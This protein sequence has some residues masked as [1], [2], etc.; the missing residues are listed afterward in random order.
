MRRASY[1]E[2]A[3]LADY[4]DGMRTSAT[5]APGAQRASDGSHLETERYLLRVVDH[6]G[7]GPV[8]LRLRGLYPAVRSCV[9]G[10]HRGLLLDD[11]SRAARWKRQQPEACQEDRLRVTGNAGC[12]GRRPFE[13]KSEGALLCLIGNVGY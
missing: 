6:W 2:A 8:D 10:R 9:A 12:S 4:R 1:R 11:I 3:A 7:T 5:T 13:I